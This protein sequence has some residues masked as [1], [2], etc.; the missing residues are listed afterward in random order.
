MKIEPVITRIRRFAESTPSKIAIESD[1]RNVTY[2]ELE[3]N[4]NRIASFFTT[5]P[6]NNSSRAAIILDRSAL[7]VETLTGLLKCGIIFAP[8]N[9]QFPAERM[10]RMIH[11]IQAGWVVTNQENFTKFKDIL[12]ETSCRIFVLEDENTTAG[13]GGVSSVSAVLP[14]QENDHCYI[15]FTSGSTGEPRAI[16]GL[17]RSLDHFINWEIE[18][19]QVD[20][21]FK[22]S[23]F[24]LPSFD[25]SLRDIFV[26]LAVG[27]TCCIPGNATLAEPRALVQWLDDKEINLVH[28][29]PSLFKQ[30]TTAAVA[31]TEPTS[32]AHRF[33]SLKYIMLAGELL[34][35][36]DV[37][38]FMGAFN[39]RIQL[40]NFYGCTE[41]TMIKLFYPLQ[42]GDANRSL[43]PVGQPIDGAQVMIL[44]NKLRRC[45]PG[46]KGE[47]YIRTPFRSA[48]YDN[49][50]QANQQV[51][52]K[53]PYGKHEQDL[54]YKTGDTGR[55]LPDG[56]F[57]V[58]GRMDSQVK[59]KGARVEPG[60]IENRLLQ[61][62]YVKDA[63]ALAHEDRE[64]EKFLTAYV[65]P[66]YNEQPAGQEKSPVHL[67]REYLAQ[68]LP[69]YMVPA[70]FVFL[71]KFPL[72]PGGKIDRAA[73]PLPTV[74][75]G[76][77]GTG[78]VIGPR[79][80]L[81]QSLV[82]IWQD[83]L[84]DRARGRKQTGID[85]N[86]FQ[87]GGHS[88][89]AT[90][91]AAKI[92]QATGVVLPIEELFL[93]PTIRELAEFIRSRSETPG[94]S[95]A[96]MTGTNEPIL[97]GDSDRLGS[98]TPVPTVEEKEYY[99]LTPG[100]ER[101][102][103]LHSLEG[104]RAVYNIWGARQMEGELDRERLETA[105]K[106][107][108]ERHE[109]LRTCFFLKDG[110]AVQGIRATVD[111]QV[112]YLQ[113]IE[114]QQQVGTPKSPVKDQV[115]GRIRDFIRPFK[116]DQAP[117]F[118]L[119]VLPLSAN[120]HLLIN[121]MH[122]IIADGM[123]LAILI[124]DFI[125]LYASQGEDLP[126]LTTRY[127]D[128][129]EWYKRRL[130]RGESQ[131]Q[132]AYWSE[133]LAG[134]IPVLDLPADFPRPPVQGFAGRQIEHILAPGLETAIYDLCRE[135]DVTLYM[136]LL[137]AFNILLAKLSG[138]QDI[139]M[140][141]PV[142]GRQHADLENVAGLFIHTLVM[143]NFPVAEKPFAL[144][145]KEVKQGTIQAFANQEYPFSRILQ[146]IDVKRDVSRNPLFDAMFIVQ[147]IE[148]TRQ[149]IEG[150]SF[151][152][153]ECERQTAKVDI[154]LEVLERPST[155]EANP[156]LLNFEYRT[157][158]FKRGT[159][160]RMVQ[161]FQFILEQVTR[162]PQLKLK[163]IH[164]L[165]AGEREQLLIKLNE[166]R[167]A[168]DY[169]AHL[170][171]HGLFEQEVE[172]RPGQVILVGKRTVGELGSI[173]HE[174]TLTYSECNRR[175]QDVAH[176][177]KEKGAGPGSIVA[178]MPGRTAGIV[179][180]L[181]GILKTG[182]AYLPIT[183]DTPA[184][185][186]SYILSYSNANLLLTSG[187]GN[188]DQFVIENKSL[189]PDRRLPLPVPA[190]G[191]G[192][193][194]GGPGLAYVIFTS[195]STGNPKGV[196]ISHRNLINLF[197]GMNRM[198]DLQSVQT[199]LS[200]TTISFDIFVFETLG[201]ALAGVKIIMADDLE[202]KNPAVI[203]RIIQRQQVDFLQ[204]TPSRLQLLLSDEEYMQF[205][206]TIRVILVAGEAFPPNLFKT[207]K[208]F[209][210]GKIYNM[211]GPTETTVYSTGKDLTDQKRITI[212]TPLINTQVYI[213]DRHFNIQPRGVAGELVIGGEGV[214]A[215]YLDNPELT[216]EKFISS[217]SHRSYL[218]PA[219]PL[220]KFYR[221]QAC[222]CPATSHHTTLYKTGDLCRW[223][224]D[225]NIEF[226]GRIDRQV[227]IRGF[228]VE[229]GEIEKRLLKHEDV[230]EAVVIDR[231]E[232]PGEKYLCAYLV[233]AQGNHSQ[234]LFD[235]M[236]DYL[237]TTLPPYM[238]PAFFV[239]VEVIPLTPNGKIDRKALPLPGKNS[240]KKYS[241]PREEKE[242]ILVDIW[243]LVLGIESG[244]IGIDD[245]FFEIGGHSLRAVAGRI[246]RVCVAD[247]QSG[248]Q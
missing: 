74:Q 35:G 124:R 233:L 82:Q 101:M 102:Y 235:D 245:N 229:L 111:F 23:Q 107:L 12:E 6:G 151:A 201:A 68:H 172:R 148:F 92:H 226:L 44:D 127:R 104:D 70:S 185:R 163:D 200:L 26:P 45:K 80:A 11:S 100:Q 94:T 39:S 213:L 33:K 84:G 138:Q 208:T 105:A 199:I 31:D 137:A 214:G 167:T 128:Y 27:G 243:A 15:Y 240:G 76:Q 13:P 65:I 117:L 98:F 149:E 145:L 203:C 232:G 231:D 136:L 174:V 123:S 155:G 87:S 79:D 34:R 115:A 170:T 1:S 38:P 129:C 58:S 86:F 157:D 81:E 62:E 212:G 143:R 140:G 178:I 66:R 90:L 134:E 132:E 47:V 121:S 217:K 219:L 61:H 179:A 141:S 197:A 54:I 41:T 110:K 93:G 220:K 194:A 152:R 118:R 9:P 187:D 162:D 218:S 83:V 46:K 228:R 133:R 160:E 120:Q 236:R 42:P 50:P 193:H 176:K 139:I 154:T 69:L 17:R 191:T 97:T 183:P 241:A 186:V 89:K 75:P 205:F 131:R 198:V 10:K 225:G 122:H 135:Q 71:E 169:P 247:I 114:T 192:Q 142:A 91:L 238:I 51:F 189:A 19:F 32:R 103:I 48:G 56:S 248:R 204:F 85:D 24:T 108:I 209:Y 30:L 8:L 211:Y 175:A 215:G 4:S 153:Y 223:L 113:P 195:G 49:N 28:T 59:I 146:K 55:Q 206:K 37:A 21:S 125:Y 29:V 63:L 230:K 99:P 156:N 227:K 40:V 242:R 20:E 18:Q 106:Q 165:T 158:L 184:A 16:L 244:K 246:G 25:P 67:L 96:G 210:R 53:N 78:E 239:K 88:L 5:S 147:N 2:A 224:D 77:P 171:V 73:L 182:A 166:N 161:Q 64:G 144:F 43:I 150:L 130:G 180:G 207:L 109:S 237:S 95:K 7:L 57:E 177:L 119:G 190:S 22:V 221:L 52:I 14:N 216:S 168:Q 159:I 3:Q 222:A 181:I 234:S 126:R 72:T 36:G 188:R 112:E 202:S 164:I 173:G 196:A 116:L 60:E